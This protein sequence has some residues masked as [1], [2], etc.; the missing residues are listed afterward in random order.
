MQIA[1]GTLKGMSLI[2]CK[3][4]KNVHLLIDVNIIKKI[5]KFLTLSIDGIKIGT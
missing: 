2:I 4:Q 3:L 1:K 5:K